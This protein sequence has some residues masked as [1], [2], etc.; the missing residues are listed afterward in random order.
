[1]KRKTSGKKWLEFSM[2][3]FNGSGYADKSSV[4][5]YI[6]SYHAY[7]YMKRDKYALKM[8]EQNAKHLTK[9]AKMC[10]GLKDAGRKPSKSRYERFL[11]VYDPYNTK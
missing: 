10:I 1:M 9:L 6:A 3:A 5:N 4:N 2:V 11:R 8:I 7:K